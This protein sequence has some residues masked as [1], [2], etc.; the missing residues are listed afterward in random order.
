MLQRLVTLEVLNDREIVGAMQ[1]CDGVVV[2]CDVED[3][4]CRRPE[5]PLGLGSTGRATPAYLTEQ[6]AMTEVRSAPG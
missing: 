2:W 6:L 3:P 4:A 1:M 5:R